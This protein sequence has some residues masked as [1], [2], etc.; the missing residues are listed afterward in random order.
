VAKTQNSPDL[1]TAI[2]A[3]TAAKPKPSVVSMSC[4]SRS[5]IFNG[6]N[7]QTEQSYDALFNTPGITFVASSGDTGSGA[8][9]PAASSIVV[10]VGGTTLTLDPTGKVQSEV[11][12]TG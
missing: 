4:G 8:F 11:A 2:A 3:A 12:W 1:L 10:G 9:F 6:I 5:S 7:Q